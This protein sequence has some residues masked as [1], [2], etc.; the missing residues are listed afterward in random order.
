MSTTTTLKQITSQSTYHKLI[1]NILKIIDYSP[2][3]IKETIINLN[4]KINASTVEAI[5]N[6]LNPAEQAKLTQQ[7]K[8]LD[9]PE[10]QDIANILKDICNKQ[11]NLSDFSKIL[12][13][14]KIQ[15]FY[16][17]FK[18]IEKDMQKNKEDIKK[19]LQQTQIPDLT[20]KEEQVIL[21]LTSD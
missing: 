7:I 2:K 10:L 4:K 1:T 13:Q 11:E 17:F 3:K 14:K 9:K 15:V 5:T 20:A 16:A 18:S 21:D 8:S 6:K 19:L 12:A